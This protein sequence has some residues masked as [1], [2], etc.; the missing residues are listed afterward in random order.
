MEE[1]TRFGRI[2]TPGEAPLP[3]DDLSAEMYS[4]AS[5]VLTASGFDHYEVSNYAKAHHQCKHNMV[6]WQNRPYYAFGMVRENTSVWFGGGIKKYAK[7][8]KRY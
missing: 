5:E 6:Y 8:C 1:G 7:S 4:T 2:Y 3:N